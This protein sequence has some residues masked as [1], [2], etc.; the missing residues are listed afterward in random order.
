MMFR[1][2]FLHFVVIRVDFVLLDD[3]LAN[4]SALCVYK[5]R[6]YYELNEI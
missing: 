2:N 4:V 5:S 6:F 1:Q 3:V